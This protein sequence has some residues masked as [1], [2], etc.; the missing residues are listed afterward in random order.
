[1]KNTTLFALVAASLSLAVS[2]STGCSSSSTGTTT[3]GSGGTGTTTTTTTTGTA[4][5]T[6]GSTTTTTT[7]G[8]GGG[9]GGTVPAPPTLGTQIDRIG[10]PAV[11]TALNHAFDPT[12]STSGPAKDAYNANSDPT[13]WAAGYVPEFEKNL[14]IVDALDGT[15][16]NQLGHLAPTTAA[17]NGY[18]TLAGA[19]ADDRLYLNTAGTTDAQ[20]LAVEVNAL[21]VKANTDQGGRALGFVVLDTTYSAL[22]AGMFSGVSNGITTNNVSFS[23]TFPYEAAPN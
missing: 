12:T 18:A 2:A 14:A 11:N 23:T 8:T 6:G 1:M 13:T 10:R 9:D 21:G 22:A 20:Y 5:A 19:L 17:P 4:T 3:T 15:C 7:T 16:G